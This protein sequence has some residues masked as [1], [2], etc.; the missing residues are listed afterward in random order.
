MRSFIVSLLFLG[1]FSPLGVSAK[2]LTSRLGVGISDQFATDTLPSVAVKYYPSA[3]LGF[4][5]ALAVDTEKDNSKFGFLV[6]MY[7]ILPGG[8]MEENLNF[9]MGGGA[10]LLSIESNGDNDSGF[11]LTGFTGAEFFFSGLDNLSFSFEAGIGIV[12][13]SSEVRFRTIADHPFKAG[14]TFYF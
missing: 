2:D 9:Y 14:I 7:K 5:A 10:G 12:S 11:E 1:V 4:S 6:K 8:F 3:D 13:I